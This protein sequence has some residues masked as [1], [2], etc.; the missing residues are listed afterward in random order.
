MAS[1]A[2]NTPYA[3]QRCTNLGVTR[4]EAKGK[5]KWTTHSVAGSSPAR[6]LVTRQADSLEGGQEGTTRNVVLNE[7]S[8]RPHRRLSSADTLALLRGLAQFGSASALGAE[9]RRFKSCISDTLD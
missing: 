6:S 2:R 8:P 5:G 7:E 4:S 9:G 1:P 3:S